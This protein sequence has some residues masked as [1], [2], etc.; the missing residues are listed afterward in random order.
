MSS[1]DSEKMLLLQEEVRTLSQ[2]LAQCQADKEFVWSLWKRLQVANPDLTQA[3]SLVVEREKHKAEAKDRKVLEILQVKD[4]KIQEL[5]KEVRSQQQERSRLLQ[6]QNVGEENRH[7]MKELVELQH[8]LSDTTRRLQECDDV[9]RRRLEEQQEQSRKLE[10][11]HNT[12]LKECEDGWRRRLEEQQEQSR[13]LEEEKN[14]RLRECEDQWRRR[15]EE[16][17]EQSRK[18]EEEKNTRLRQLQEEL[19][20]VQAVNS[21]LSVQLRSVQQNLSDR[22]PQLQQLRSELQNLQSLYVQS[23]AHAGEQAE[24]IQQLEGLNMDTQQILQSQERVHTTHTASYHKLYS[25]LSVSYQALRLSEEQLR[26]RDACLTEQLSQKEQQ[27]SELQLQILQLQQLVPPC[28]LPPEECVE[29]A[30]SQECVS[31]PPP[32]ETQSC[33]TCTQQCSRS[34]SPSSS[35]AAEQKIQQL[36]ELLTLKTAEN[37]ELRRAHA[38]RHD[39]LRLIQTNYRTVK[40]Q[41]KEVED[42]QDLPKGRTR[43][44]EAWELR[45]ENSDAVW[46]ELAFFKRENKKLL[47]EKAQLEE[48]L[49]VARVRVAMERATAQ[50]LRLRLH[51]E[52]Q[53]F[54]QNDGDEDEDRV[55]STPL[56]PVHRLHRS[57]RK[58]EMLE[59]KMMHLEKETLKLQED[60]QVLQDAN[61]LLRSKR[62]EDQAALQQAHV[63]EEATQARVNAERNRLLSDIRALQAQLEK[64][65]RAETASR[66]AL[67][68]IR[69]EVGVLRAER[70]FHRNKTQRG[71]GRGTHVVTQTFSVKPRTRSPAKDEWEDMSPDSDSGDSLDS[72]ENRR[73]ARPLRSTTHAKACAALPRRPKLRDRSTVSRAHSTVLQQEAALRKRRRSVCVV[74]KGA[75]VCEDAAVRRMRRRRRVCAVFTRRLACLQQQ[76]AVL[77]AASRSAQDERLKY[78]H[79]PIELQTLTHTVQKQTSELALLQQ[80]KA[81]LEAELEQWRKPRPLEAQQQVSAPPPAPDLPNIKTLETEIR[82]LNN[83]LKS[84]SAEVTRQSALIKSLRT[85]LHDRDQCV[86]E[87]QD[88]VCQCER[89]VVMKR[90]LVEDLR[91]RLKI[92]QDS[93]RSQRSHIDELEKKVKSQ[94]EEASNRKAF[95]E[96][97]K[98]R[99][100]VATQ[101][102]QQCESTNSTLR[103]QIH[104]KEQKLTALQARFVEC[105]RSKVELE[106][107][108]TAQMKLL[109]NQSTETIHTLQNK[110]TLAQT[111]HHHLRSVTQALA[112]EVDRQVRDTRAELRK[113]RRERKKKEESTRG[114]VSKSSMVKAQSIAAS[115][116]NVSANDLASILD[117]D[118]EEEGGDEADGVWMDRIQQLLQQRCPSVGELVDVLVVKMKENRALMEELVNLRESH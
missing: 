94:C 67:L 30:E 104:T 62:A 55:S 61:D 68:R 66:A 41:L 50:E 64:S 36:E 82:H 70:D 49:D 92:L 72:L 84:S 103:D 43:R 113:R 54:Q 69:Q 90:Q 33:G 83:R 74:V 5:E 15:L 22:E 18:Q 96:S 107:A 23:V 112:V 25:E 7:V 29:A 13:K 111:Q 26:Q 78:Q 116:L 59:R 79:M 2:E 40:E 98:R 31:Q 37:E 19:V 105:E 97:L 1:T 44:A 102:K 53:E 87:L 8:T 28:P 48:E 99:L 32:S 58:I 80:Q 34:V 88:K 16:Q 100:S 117:T 95:I 42:K 71:H 108:A 65:H 45:Q 39:R 52:Q 81:V 115:I 6:Q 46:N 77:Q 14:A 75:G 4:Y 3:V 114:G 10:E 35:R 17:Q 21:S 20:K 9:W 56:P 60:K 86:K 38:K 11:T 85:E 24:L 110:L 93:E 12:R 91:S 57:V 51:Q 118:Q 109:T 106:Q 47:T 63:R 89:D 76:V 27:V 73:A 101:D